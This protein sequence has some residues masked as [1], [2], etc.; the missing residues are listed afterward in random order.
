MAKH[1]KKANDSLDDS[2]D[3]LSPSVSNLFDFRERKNGKARLF[4]PPVGKLCSQGRL[5]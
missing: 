1:L 3:I 2:L 5:E 4:S